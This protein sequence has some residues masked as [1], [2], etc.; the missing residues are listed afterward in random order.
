MGV[1]VKGKERKLVSVPSRNKQLWLHHIPTCTCATVCEAARFLHL[2]AARYAASRDCCSGC[3]AGNPV[4]NPRPASAPSPTAQ[5]GAAAAAGGPF[6]PDQAA[7]GNVGS[8]T[9]RAFEAMEA[10]GS[11]HAPAGH[12]DTGTISDE[13]WQPFQDAPVNRSSAVGAAEHRRRPA[14]AWADDSAPPAHSQSVPVSWGAEMAR[15]RTRAASTS[16]EVVPPLL[17]H[18]KHPAHHPAA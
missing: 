3:C 13:E 7:P 8:A 12:L 1:T 9:W 10:V 4:I 14:D 11:R 15:P 18:Y 16:S 6:A 2:Y 5:R 17:P